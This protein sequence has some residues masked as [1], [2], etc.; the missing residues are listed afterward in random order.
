MKAS[1]RLFIKQ[2]L[3]TDI[4]FRSFVNSYYFQQVINPVFI[5][6]EF[7]DKNNDVNCSLQEIRGKVWFAS[8]DWYHNTSFQL[9]K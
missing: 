6:N 1:Y 7:S 2:H 8:I 4:F 3:K 9:Y 5:V